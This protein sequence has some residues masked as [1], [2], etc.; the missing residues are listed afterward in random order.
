M[1]PPSAF[2]RVRRAEA[3]ERSSCALLLALVALPPGER[4]RRR[5]QETPAI[6]PILAS[7][8]LA[9]GPNRFLFS[10]TDPQGAPLAAPDV[11]V[12]LR[13][14]DDDVDPE[15]VVF[16][17]DSRFLWAIEGVRGL[18]AADVVFPDAGRWGTRFD[19]TFPDGR[20]ETVRAD[21]D[22]R[23]TTS[24]PAIGAPAPRRGLARRPRTSAVTCRAS[25]RTR[26]PSRASTSAPS[27]TPSRPASRPSSPSSRRPSASRAPAAPPSRR[28][29]RWPRRHPEVSVVQVEPYLMQVKD[30]V[31]Q[32]LLS[33]EG[34]LQPAPW[35]EAWG[36]VTEPFV[37]VVDADGLVRAKFEGA[38]TAEELE[39]ALPCSPDAWR[40]GSVWRPGRSA[41]GR[42]T[43][44]RAAAPRRRPSDATMAA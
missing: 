19:A 30:G 3:C 35:T 15:A 17:A 8:E 18:Y 40:P 14:Y 13:F 38:V 11:S 6:I 25:P 33:A 27:P 41:A 21:Y 1:A 39:A 10:L 37:A 26:S 9:A 34:W 43:P 20:Q 2:V 44:C 16:E 4:A 24:T 32:P 12:H 36:L 31:L 23:E 28:S 42:S 5:P 29:R 7:S 22:V